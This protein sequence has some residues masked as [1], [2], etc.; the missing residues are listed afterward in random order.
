MLID[1]SFVFGFVLLLIDVGV[2]LMVVGFCIVCWGSLF[3]FNCLH[4]LL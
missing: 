1:F 3:Y 2:W 4:Y